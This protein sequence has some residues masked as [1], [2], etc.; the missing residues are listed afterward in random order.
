V[1]RLLA[2]RAAVQLPLL[3]A[4]LAVVVIG[5]SLLGVCTLLL[6]GSQER[7]LDTGVRRAEPDAVDATAYV[8]G[9]TGTIA[10]GV[11]ADTR[12][13][14]TRAY[15]PLPATS[16]VQATSA[17]RSLAGHS[18]GAPR[19]GYLSGFDDLPS[20]SRLTAGRWPAAG[21]RPGKIEAVVLEPTARRL[22]LTLGSKVTLGSEV[23]N[24]GRPGVSV[25]IVGV[26]A[27]RPGTTPDWDLLGATGYDPAYAD[28]THALRDRA[29]GPF[30]V[31]LKDLYATG[32]TLDRLQVRVHP[33]L[34]A[35]TS[36][37]LSA[38]STSLGGADARLSATLGDRV[39]IER[40]ASD[41]PD[42]VFQAK[43]QLAVTRSTV[44]IVVLLGAVLTAVALGLAGR[45]V[46]ALR[47]TQTALLSALGA[48]R[49][50]L[51][52]AAAVEA[53]ALAAL[54]VALAIP[55][56]GLAHSAL[57]HLPAPDAAGLAA[58]PGASPGQVSA[59]VVGALLLTGVLVV[60]ALRPDPALAGPTRG[61]GGLLIRSGADLALLALAVAGWWQLRSQPG[62]TPGP[63]TVRVVAPVLCLLAGAAVTVRL[64]PAPL[65]IGERLA[66]RSRGLVL[67]LAAFEAARRPRAVAAALLLSL[68]AAAGSFGLAFGATWQASQRDQA[69]T[70]V[71]TDLSLALSGAATTGQAEAVRA[72]TGGTVSPA[73]VRNAT[74]GSWVG[75]SA[76]PTRL[77]AVDTARAG[78]LLRGR[79]P[80]GRTWAGV[81]R[82]LSPGDPVAG[83]SLGTGP[84]TLTGSSSR[85]AQLQVTPRLEVQDAGGLR[86]PCDAAPVT[87]D[88][89]PHPLQLCDELSGGTRTGMSLVALALQISADPA[90]ESK[91]GTAQV[92]VTL[93]LPGPGKGGSAA[94]VWQAAPAGDDDS[95]QMLKTATVQVHPD[96]AGGGTQLSSTAT[97]DL[98][99]LG[100]QP[101]DLVATGFDPPQAVPV[102][103]SDQL[104]HGLSA[105]IG[106]RLDVTVDSTPVAAVIAQ[107]VPT[108]P[109]A[110]G[111]P[112][113]LADLD[114]LS[115]ILIGTGDL[116]PPVDA[117]WVGRP[118]RPDAA[119]RATA[120]GLGQVR[121]RAEV[122]SQLT[123][124]PLRVGLPLALTL[125]VPAAV[126][127]ALAGQFLQ[128]SSE[129]ESRAL[130]MARLRG[131]GLSRR[132]VRRSLLVQ[133][134]AVLTLLIGAGAVNGALASWVLGPLLNR[135]DLGATPVP[136]TQVHWP[137]TAEFGLLAGLLLGS[138]GA[139]ALVITLQL[140]RSSAAE[141]RVAR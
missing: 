121:T 105:K 24:L 14:L 36:T 80:D 129:L 140:R 56:S 22:G 128:I 28:A 1:L 111:A 47:A 73:T 122:S 57:T 58:A 17:V 46:T 96:A 13:E 32:S 108:I 12:A 51:L 37:Q 52:A 138:I 104:L 26:F 135:S 68:A 125:L 44:L 110:P 34:S 45:L 103:V 92:A 64:L 55:L 16:S 130:E 62:T 65:W 88:G 4:V 83:L 100:Y 132:S 117:W 86:T 137:W 124:G 126:L 9:E 94:P 69:D 85:G 67:S 89:D 29:Y 127:L 63:D 59:V 50:Q 7:A 53:A 10:P 43:V 141:L 90:A 5:A 84:I 76:N 27:P 30:V 93:G 33:D 60:P 81:G 139:V 2:R 115:R 54:A 42:T 15:A 112:A 116:D 87:L 131:L 11:V 74:V 123:S 97:V 136:V 25:V 82:A 19:V 49:G 66:L 21:A 72:A 71:G 119:A 6:T 98:S 39:P 40:V 23:G 48:S 118:A 38:V 20:W 41:L 75:D 95:Q 106:D 133:H 99:G 8:G 101:A 31:D 79:L 91:D 114:Q 35:A 78:T 107:V 3:A 77:V 70:R 61:G 109:A 120:L 113:L 18:P 134:G 102:A